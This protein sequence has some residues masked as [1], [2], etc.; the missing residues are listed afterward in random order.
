MQ[1]FFWGFAFWRRN[2]YHQGDRFI[3]MKGVAAITNGERG[4]NDRREPKDNVIL[5]PKT[6]DYY[7]IQLTRMLETERYGEAVELLRFLLSVNSGDPRNA[8]EW[9]ALL[10]WMQSMLPG[11]E[12]DTSLAED[13]AEPEDPTEEKLL[14]ESVGRKQTADDNYVNRLLQM[15]RQ[16]TTLEKIML[17]LGQLAY[18]NHPEVTPALLAWVKEGKLHPYILFHA[19]QALRRRGAA[20]ALT[21]RHPEGET[22]VHIED[23]PL[24]LSDHPEPLLA[25]LHRVQEKSEVVDP[26]LAYFAEQSW[27]D[28][29]SFIYASPQYLRL[30]GLDSAGLDVWAAALHRTLGELIHGDEDSGDYRAMYAITDEYLLEWKQASQI[31]ESFVRMRS[32]P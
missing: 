18:V 3:I 9:E 20:G 19:L 26:T 11:T 25:V 30:T 31:L 6:V 5:F 8:Q 14:R 22:E 27:N 21:I 10:G 2:G 13:K 29:L 16:G 7:Q 12:F 15:L 24:T 28:F 1:L 32:G 23:T 4:D 17:A